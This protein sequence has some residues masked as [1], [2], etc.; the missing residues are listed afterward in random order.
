MKS[1]EEYE[2]IAGG[3]EEFM[4]IPFTVLT[5]NRHNAL[6]QSNSLRNMFDKLLE[7]DFSIPFKTITFTLAIIG[8]LWIS[9][10]KAFYAQISH[11]KATI[12]SNET[13]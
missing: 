12:S 4:N 7:P 10:W 13:N 9:L 11:R 5:S 6:I 3:G 1:F 8:Y 2:N